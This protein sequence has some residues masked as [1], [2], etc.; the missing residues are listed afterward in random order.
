[1][2]S[3]GSDNWDPFSFLTGEVRTLTCVVGLGQH[4]QLGQLVGHRLT[5]VSGPAVDDPT[6][7]QTRGPEPG[8]VRVKPASTVS[9]PVRTPGP[10]RRTGRGPEER[11]HEERGHEER[12]T[13]GERRRDNSLCL[14]SSVNDPLIQEVKSGGRPPPPIP[15]LF[16]PKET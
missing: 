13:Q 12:R 2:V 14:M 7:L 11:G 16:T 10:P 9:G 4:A 8:S 6:A 1:M 3:Q 5:A 15:R